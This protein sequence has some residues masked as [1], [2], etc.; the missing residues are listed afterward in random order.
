M[1]FTEKLA[2]FLTPEWRSQYIHY[3]QLK[4]MIVRAVDNAPTDQSDLRAV[5]SYYAVIDDKFFERCDM[6][7]QKVN[8]FFA[9]K[10]AEAKRKHVALKTEF[11]DNTTT[12]QN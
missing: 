4:E 2:T 3:E 1:K 6:E 12:T 11:L 5:Q 7:L 8:T 9:E 10:L